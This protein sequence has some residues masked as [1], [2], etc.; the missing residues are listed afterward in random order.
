MR[1]V[2]LIFITI[3]ALLLA[4][5]ESH[6]T[7]WDNKPHFLTIGGK[8]SIGRPYYIQL[9]TSKSL[10][11]SFCGGAI[12]DSGVVATAAHCIN[13][14]EKI[15]LIHTPS[16][17][18]P[19]SAFEVNAIVVHE[20]YSPLGLEN[21]IALLFFDESKM[22]T[23]MKI[24][25]LNRA[26]REFDRLIATGRGSITSF[27]D[28][29][30]NLL[31]EVELNYIS[32]EICNRLSQSGYD[33][34]DS[35]LC[36]GDI[37]NGGR[38]TCGGDSG[39]PLVEESGD[40]LL[41]GLVSF[42]ENCGQQNSP[43]KYTR[44]SSFTSWI[45]EKTRSFK[46]L[47]RP[48]TNPDIELAFN[49]YCYVNGRNRQE[50]SEDNDNGAL[51]VKQERLVLDG[52]FKEMSN[53]QP[54][55]IKS[56][57]SFSLAKDHYTA[58]LRQSGS[59]EQ[60]ILVNKSKSRTWIA[61]VRPEPINLSF[62]C[63]GSNFHQPIS[64]IID[65]GL[66]LLASDEKFFLLSSV[67][68]DNRNA[69]PDDGKSCETSSAKLSIFSIG[70][71]DGDMGLVLFRDK[72][73]NKDSLFSYSINKPLERE[74]E[75][76]AKISFSTKNKGKFALINNSSTLILYSWQLKCDVPFQ[77]AS[78]GDFRKD[79]TFV[80]PEDPYSQLNPGD[81]LT[82]DIEFQDAAT[83]PNCVL[84]EELDVSIEEP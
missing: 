21:D 8:S 5:T 44:V 57:C 16:E 36:A 6:G 33:V 69:I 63:T 54:E 55:D 22:T 46:E 19:I 38:D 37:K 52:S 26:R 40:G 68:V 59:R 48:G 74:F 11:D 27:G 75:L 35:M 9:S 42:G 71:S 28:I 43:G 62:T 18:N 45:E 12:I 29:E 25:P 15:F 77:L 73:T 50:F 72:S 14:L 51:L 20:K 31:R 65:E 79:K 66:A 34:T 2:H 47:Q 81:K 80:Y 53:T 56:L 84:N 3:V 82:L 10:D 61:D 4:Y 70:G 67:L 60:V 76:E 1:A 58:I 30:G 83:A 39:G 17:S 49:S 41:V 32:N 13:N 78:S 64:F 23:Q 7:S 24:I